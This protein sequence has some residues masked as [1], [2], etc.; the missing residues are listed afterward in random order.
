[1]IWICAIGLKASIRLKYYVKKWRLNS[2]YLLGWAAISLHNESLYISLCGRGVGFAV[3]QGGADPG[4]E[5]LHLLVAVG[6]AI[7]DTIPITA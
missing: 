2:L 1:M 5:Q 3:I 7:V 6:A 4:S